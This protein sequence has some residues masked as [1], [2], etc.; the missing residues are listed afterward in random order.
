MQ[1][2]AIRAAGGVTARGWSDVKVF[3]IGHKKPDTDSICSVL[4]YAEL[5]NHFEPG[6]YVAAR[7]GELNA[8]T[9]YVLSLFHHEPPLYIE[10]VEPNVADLPFT[11]TASAR[12][13]L[14]TIDVVAMMD[15]QDLRNMPIT[16][17]EGR[18]LGLFSEHGLARAYV[19]RQAIEPLSI[20]PIKLETLARILNGRI[21]VPAA[22]L[23]E[24]TVYIA[25]DAL[26]VT[27]SRLRPNDVAIVGDN[28]PAQLA[29]ISAGIAL[30]IIADDAPV[31]EARSNGVALLA[32]A[33]DAV[34]VGKMIN[35]SLPA[36]QV[37]A[38]DAPTVRMEDSLAYVKQLV[39]NSRYRTA[40]VVGEDGRLLGMISRNTFL[41]DVRKSV[42]LLDHNEYTQAVD[43]IEEA[44]ILEI[45]DHHRLGAIS[46]LKPIRF[47]NDPVGST[48]TIVTIKFME[49]AIDPA[50]ETAGILLGGILSDTLLLKLSTTTAQD[51][52]AVA[53]LAPLAGVDPVAFGTEMIARGMALE[54]LSIEELLTRDMK[55]YQLFGKNIMISQVMVPSFA[56]PQH[57]RDA[58]LLEV[59]RLRDSTGSDAFAALFTDI[60]ENASDLF[61]AADDA[62]LAALGYGAQPVRLE[63]VMSRKKDF[64]PDFGQKIRNL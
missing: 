57:N 38:T 21:V 53:Y 51:E 64:L 2:T 17:S 19:R 25:I 61:L 44:E 14:P 34:G 11:Y 35:L 7:C 31:G 52:Q 4:G 18:Y 56:Y 9:E 28:E 63:G 41:D 60:F 42:I 13:D 54:G 48:S 23:L 40:C 12:G 36:R 3:V 46:T 24:G 50:P 62:M 29:L 27:L 32:T 47:L 30:V 5:M 26:H 20:T 49:S 58:I 8:E 37:M 6:K 55:R 45:I 33:L 39:S 10:S 59:G 16:D 15:E 43:G 1:E 22:D